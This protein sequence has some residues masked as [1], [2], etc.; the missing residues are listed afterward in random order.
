M[1]YIKIKRRAELDYFGGL[2]AKT[3]R[4]D[5]E[6]L[7][8]HGG[9]GASDADSA[10]LLA[11]L[12]EKWPEGHFDEVNIVVSAPR[13]PPLMAALD[14]LNPKVR[15]V[16]HSPMLSQKNERDVLR[17]LL[18]VAAREI[19]GLRLRRSA[20]GWCDVEVIGDRS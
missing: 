13:S 14:F 1:S 16:A 20:I 10:R 8:R 19:G 4:D 15:R 12:L 18:S 17:W 3:R 5:A 11:A 9:C 7:A 6:L 2:A